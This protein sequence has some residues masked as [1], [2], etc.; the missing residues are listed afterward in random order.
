MIGCAIK[1]KKRIISKK[2]FKKLKGIKIKEEE[3]DLLEFLKKY[4]E[5]AFTIPFLVDE[6]KLTKRK[7]TKKLKKLISEEKVEEKSGY[8]IYYNPREI[9]QIPENYGR[10]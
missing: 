10:E 3:K 5:K 2:E 9:D 8:F 6:L 7:I 4:S 1:V